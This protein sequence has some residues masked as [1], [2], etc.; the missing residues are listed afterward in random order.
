MIIQ[1]NPELFKKSDKNNIRY[2]PKPYNQDG[3]YNNHNKR[4]S[5]NKTTEFTLNKTAEFYC[6]KY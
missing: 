6:C 5:I 4:K 1:Q 2:R 3:K